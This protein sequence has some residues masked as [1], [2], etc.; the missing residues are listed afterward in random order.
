MEDRITFGGIFKSLKS[1]GFSSTEI[2]QDVL[3]FFEA[4]GKVISAWNKIYDCI[5]EDYV[6]EVLEE[7]LKM[8]IE[9][10]NFDK[11][12]EG[13]RFST[14]PKDEAFDL[15]TTLAIK[16]L[17]IDGECENFFMKDENIQKLEEVENK[18]ADILSFRK[19]IPIY[20]ISLTHPEKRFTEVAYRLKELGLKDNAI[21]E[22]IARLLDEVLEE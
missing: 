11:L 21:L 18:L 22:V 15:A 5:K 14:F 8:A 16:F 12:F 2:V 7:M 3:P 6:L 13:K 4:V 19:E 20:F 10:G 1:K 17:F 9:T